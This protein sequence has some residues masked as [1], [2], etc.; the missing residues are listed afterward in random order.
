MKFKFVKKK[1]IRG[2]IK[3]DVDL[4]F[5][6]LYSGKY[7]CDENA[8]IINLGSYKKEELPKEIIVEMRRIK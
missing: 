2:K 8:M 1:F 6:P 3:E 5:K 7:K 4:K